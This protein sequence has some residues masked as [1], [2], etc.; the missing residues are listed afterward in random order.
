MPVPW[1]LL[2]LALGR[3]PVV[4]SL[5]RLVGSQDATHCSPGLSCHLWDSDILCLPG[6][7]VPAPG[8]VLAPTHLQ[9]EL[10]LRCQK[11]TDCDLCLRV[12]VHLAVHGL[13]YCPLR[14]A[15]GASACCPC[16]VW[17]VCGLCGI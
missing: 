17:S 10:V 8:P 14:P 16:A 2:S 7:I 3:S 15:G 6:D 9:T 13:P 1:F 5:E 11:E 4:L 12:A